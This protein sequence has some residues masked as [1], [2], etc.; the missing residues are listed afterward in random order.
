MQLRKHNSLTNTHYSV[1]ACQQ[2]CLYFVVLIV[3]KEII[4]THSSR[5][6]KNECEMLNYNDQ[7]YI[8]TWSMLIVSQVDQNI[9]TNICNCETVSL[10]VISSYFQ[11][12]SCLNF[13]GIKSSVLP[14]RGSHIHKDTLHENFLSFA[15][16]QTLKVGLY[17]TYFIRS[18]AH[19]RTW[20]TFFFILLP[21]LQLQKD[22]TNALKCK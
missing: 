12:C 8:S 4:C 2:N 13:H 21:R 20:N 7:Y 22:I 11:V 3:V 5:G 17:R 16:L 1:L 14:F 19:L 15:H 18:L 10:Y 6:V 9:V